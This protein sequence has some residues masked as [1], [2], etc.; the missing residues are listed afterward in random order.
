MDDVGLSEAK[1]LVRIDS[2]EEQQQFVP[3]KICAY[4]IALYI[5]LI[6]H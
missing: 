1:P 3:E 6:I 5:M 2:R 4:N